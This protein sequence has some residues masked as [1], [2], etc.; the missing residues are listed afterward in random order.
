MSSAHRRTLTDKDREA[1]ERAG[2]AL[3]AEVFEACTKAGLPVRL[4]K[5]KKAILFGAPTR[6]EELHDDVAAQLC[7][8]YTGFSHVVQWGIRV[9]QVYERRATLLRDQS[10][11]A[12]LNMP[13]LV[14]RIRQRIDLV[15]RQRRG[16]AAR[17]EAQA[18]ISADPRFLEAKKLLGRTLVGDAAA[19]LEVYE[20]KA[21]LTIK[22]YPPA[23]LDKILALARAVQVR[24]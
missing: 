20:G 18:S 1:L 24:S 23:D 6:D 15:E 9:P 19:H 21:Q 8:T 3:V 16:E 7:D 2:L 10:Y 5:G 17:K 11:K 14:D 12:P 22:L 4:A 13:K